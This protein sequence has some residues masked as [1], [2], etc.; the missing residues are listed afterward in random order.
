M[1]M[2]IMTAAIMLM[3]WGL[4]LILLGRKNPAVG[5]WGTVFLSVPFAAGMSLAA[6]VG[7]VMPWHP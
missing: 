7:F 1:S 5:F 3:W 4:A 2:L 6:Y